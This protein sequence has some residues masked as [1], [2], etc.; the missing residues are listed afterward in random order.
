LRSINDKR[1]KN[2]IEVFGNFLLPPPI[3][4]IKM[5]GPG[6]NRHGKSHSN[7]IILLVSYRALLPLDLFDL[8]TLCEERGDH[9][10]WRG[11]I[12]PLGGHWIDGL[13]SHV[14]QG[15]LF[16]RPAS[17]FGLIF[18]PNQIGLVFYPPIHSWGTTSS[19]ASYLG[20]FSS[21]C[22]L[23]FIGMVPLSFA[24]NNGGLYGAN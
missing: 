8:S 11:G 19:T 4:F 21:T 14:E 7:C 9:K 24:V 12:N 10:M 5:E 1:T 3:P 2:V 15:G 13:P 16:A 17:D 18:P 22:L 20:H 23:I 6:L